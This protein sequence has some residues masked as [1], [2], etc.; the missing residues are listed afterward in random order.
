MNHINHL[1]FTAD[2]ILGIV[3]AGIIIVG[4]VAYFFVDR[5]R[6]KKYI[7]EIETRREEYKRLEAEKEILRAEYKSGKKDNVIFIHE[8]DLELARKE[9][10]KLP[11]IKDLIKVPVAVEDTGVIKADDCEKLIVKIVDKKVYNQKQKVI[12]ITTTQLNSFEDGEVINP[13]TLMEKGIIPRY[14]N[15]YLRVQAKA[16][17]KKA[18]F[19]QAHEFDLEAAKM[20]LLAGGEVVRV[21]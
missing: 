17:L 20:I 14:S 11:N 19:V 21:I 3:I 6:D 13:I 16:P 18:L 12:V 15:Y 2:H 8:A 5:Y 9:R 7:R 10:G 4:V 1:A